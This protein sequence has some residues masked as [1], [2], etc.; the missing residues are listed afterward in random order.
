MHIYSG[1]IGGDAL[2]LP[3]NAITLTLIT[4]LIFIAFLSVNRTG[5]KYD[6]FSKVLLLFITLTLIPFFWSDFNLAI[7]EYL[8]FIV[9]LIGSLYYLS[10]LQINKNKSF[11]LKLLL[12]ISLASLIQ[13][14][15]SLY[16]YYLFVSSIYNFDLN[17]GRPYGVFQQ[18]NTLA[19]FLVTGLSVSLFILSQYIKLPIKI[20]IFLYCNIFTSI[21]VT[22]LCE[23]RVGYITLSIVAIYYIFSRTKNNNLKIIFL[24]LILLSS[25][26]AYNL[27]YK[28]ESDKQGRKYSSTSIG[29]RI[30]IYK[31][32]LDLI[33]KKPILG[34]G[35]GSFQNTLLVQSASKA[36]QRNNVNIAH[37]VTHPHNELLYWYFE[38][39]VITLVAFLLLIIQVKKNIRKSK[40]GSRGKLLLL[41]TPIIFHSLVEL[42]FYHS[43]PHL[44]IFIIL[45]AFINSKSDHHKHLKSKKIISIVK[46]LTLVL[47][48]LV[49]IYSASAVHTSKQLFNYVQ[50]QNNRYLNAI[51]NPVPSFKSINIFSKS[52]MI[53]E[54]ILKN[55][56]PKLIELTKWTSQFLTIYPSAYLRHEKIRVLKHLK[57]LK[58]AEHETVIA[59]HLYPQYIKRWNTGNWSN[60]D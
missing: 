39:G 52:I 49:S 46:I 53:N 12:L 9:I 41:L 29:P 23:S 18:T 55:D 60:Q 56:I 7:S 22:L 28:G 25:C 58:H 10:L 19:S 4:S 37:N 26:L 51:I 42:P 43:L 45:L 11:F 44:F 48:T 2:Q 16:Q 21:W 8:R 33:L 17:Y 47:F 34:Y 50:T 31:D 5:I 27:P 14:L 36:G 54:A 40:K 13:G 1:N 15:L 6:E 24:S 59:K 20:R 30:Y 35:Y 38:G 3:F 57:Q 32:T